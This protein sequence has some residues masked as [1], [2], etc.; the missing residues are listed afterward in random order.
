MP[1]I[2]WNCLRTSF[3]MV[4]AARPTAPMVSPQNKKADIPPINAPTSTFGF[5]RF[6]WKNSMKSIMFAVVGLNKL[7]AWSTNVCPS[8]MARCIAIFISSTYEASRARAVK[9]ALPM[10]NPL[11]VAAV[12][13]PNA[14][15]AS[16]R[17]RTP[18]PSSLISALPP[19]LSAIG[20]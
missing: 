1:L 5:I 7:P 17:W 6:T 20:P 10:A 18:S 15:S 3:T 13:L 2:S 14:S 9:A 19:A 8:L 11:P 12:V 4:W 16:V